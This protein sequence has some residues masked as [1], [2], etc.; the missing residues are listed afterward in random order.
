MEWIWG[1]WIIDKK[2]A[3]WWLWKKKK[4]FLTETDDLSLVARNHVVKGKKKTNSN[5]THAG[6]LL[7]TVCAVVNIIK[8]K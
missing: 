4:V 1:I 5:L 8:K 7:A 6:F 2:V 3:T